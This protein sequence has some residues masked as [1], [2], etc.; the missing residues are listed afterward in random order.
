M[1]G[2]Y[3]IEQAK[4]GDMET[5]L[6]FA[7][8]EGWNP[9]RFDG[10][11][12]YQTDPGGFFVG[13]L[14]GKII[15]CISAVA[16]D[17]TFGFLGLYIVHPQYRGKG[18]GI[19]LWQAAMEYMGTRNVGLEGVIEQQ[20][21]YR[22][23][24]FQFV[25]RSIR[26]EGQGQGKL[27][28]SLVPCSEI[29]IENLVEFDN[30]FFPVSRKRFLHAW[31]NMP[32]AKSYAILSGK[33]IKGYGLVRPCRKGYKI[34]PLFAQ[35]SAVADEILQGLLFEAKNGPVFIDIPETN[36]GAIDLIENYRWKKVFET[37]RMYTQEAPN[38]CLS[39]IYGITT[40]ELG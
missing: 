19:L 14:S 36:S 25:H 21:N 26:Y 39:G 31:L 38:L 16:Y 22:K 33:E 7:E 20:A 8:K 11:I 9:G 23:S 32:D 18:Y 2:M 27:S 5:I 15:G 35:N 1:S 17:E 13:K 37:A 4:P 29:L 40:L 12:F 30:Q 6:S 24:G 10:P 28:A 3:R 34:G